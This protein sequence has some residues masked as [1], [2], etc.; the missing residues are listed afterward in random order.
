[1][2]VQKELNRVLCCIELLLILFYSG[3]TLKSHG[4]KSFQNILWSHD[5]GHMICYLSFPCYLWFDP[6]ICLEVVDQLFKCVGSY[7]LFGALIT[8]FFLPKCQI[9]P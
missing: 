7:F 1:V 3:C 6:V 5:P 8:F 9:L 4:H 2:N